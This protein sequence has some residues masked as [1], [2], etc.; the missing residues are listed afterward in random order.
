VRFRRE[1]KPRTPAQRL[2]AIRAKRLPWLIVPRAHVSALRRGA[3]LAFI[4]ASHA[5][6]PVDQSF[7]CERP[8]RA[9][10]VPARLRPIVQTLDRLWEFFAA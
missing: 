1:A 10:T 2:G 9:E 5:G 7:V 4:E 8:A 3:A 6:R